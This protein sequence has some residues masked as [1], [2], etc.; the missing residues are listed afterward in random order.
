M[1]LNISAH[2]RVD[3]S[4]YGEGWDGCYLTVK[5]MNPGQ[6]KEWQELITAEATGDETVDQLYGEKLKT[7]L[8]GG[9]IMNTGEDGKAARYKIDDEDI[10][11]VVDAIGPVFKQRALMIAAGTYGLKGL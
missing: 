8:V 6:L 9:V 3:L 11:D 4:D 7:I 10:A 2:R 1:S 5:S